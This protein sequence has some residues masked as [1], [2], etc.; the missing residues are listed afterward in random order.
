MKT[1]E[2]AQIVANY[3]Q[4]KKLLSNGDSNT[5]TAK[6]PGKSFNLSL[7]PFILN[8]FGINICPKASKGCALACIFETGRGIFEN[9]KK[10][11]IFKTE[12]YLRNKA[13]FVLQLAREISAKIRTAKKAGQKVYFRL[14]TFSDLD[15]VYLLKKY[16]NFDIATF[17]D[18][19][20]FYDYTAILGKALKYKGHPNYKV[21]FSRKEDN[22][23]DVL[24]A[25]ENGV[26]VAAVFYGKLPEYYKGFKVVDGDK[27]DI[28]M[29][30]YNGVIL[31]LLAKGKTAKNDKTGFV[32]QPEDAARYN[33]SEIAPAR[34]AL[35]F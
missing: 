2:I 22:E 34:H 18:T 25:L 21:T 6:N 4:P 10:G 15:F 12:F 19:A 11:R 33:Y 7:A 8:S 17:A 3:V 27:T 20:I 31:G 26:N 1:S 13:E 24:K 9:V 32:I 29:L 5:K 23:S 14:N 16:A 35:P 30:D 28:V